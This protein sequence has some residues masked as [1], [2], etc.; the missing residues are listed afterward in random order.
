MLAGG[1]HMF[2]KRVLP[3]MK[4]AEQ[5]LDAWKPVFYARG[6]DVQNEGVWPLKDAYE[7][8]SYVEKSF[9]SHGY[10]RIYF[11]MMDKEPSVRACL[12]VLLA[13][14]LMT[15]QFKK[16]N[17]MLNLSH[18]S[19]TL[20]GNERYRYDTYGDLNSITDRTFFDKASERRI[21]AWVKALN[22]KPKALKKLSEIIEPSDDYMK[23]G[24][25]IQHAR[26]KFLEGERN[27]LIT[28]YKDGKLLVIVPFGKEAT[29]RSGNR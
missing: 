2:N 28:P 18:P 25:S 7:Y 12:K 3:M 22:P 9:R 20:D 10:I 19:F 14:I 6:I 4:M 8:F 16:M 13:A 26:S 15:K 21:R 27:C 24:M 23:T 1:M 17:V 29:V 5:V 11:R